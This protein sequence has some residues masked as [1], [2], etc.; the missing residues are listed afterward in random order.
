[1]IQ[2]SEQLLFSAEQAILHQRNR[3][4]K[5]RTPYFVLTQG[6]ASLQIPGVIQDPSE[7]P[8][9][10]TINP[11]GDLSDN[12]KVAHKDLLL[13]FARCYHMIYKNRAVLFSWLP[14][15]SRSLLCKSHLAKRWPAPQKQTKAFASPWKGVWFTGEEVSVQDKSQLLWGVIWE[16]WREE[17]EWLNLSYLFTVKVFIFKLFAQTWRQKASKLNF[18]QLHG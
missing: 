4:V 17:E 10:G 18:I 12:E 9:R 8:V 3:F 6:L 11:S 5:T 16:Q 15:L 14:G 2:K 7:I 1:M 13:D